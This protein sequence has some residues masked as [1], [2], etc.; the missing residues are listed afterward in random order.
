MPNVTHE[1]C[2]QQGELEIDGVSMHI[3][4]CW[5]CTNVEQLWIP[6]AVR[7]GENV[8]IPY[9]PGR[10]AVPWRRDQAVYDVEL[11]FAG[12]NDENGTDWPDYRQGLTEN[13][14][15]FQQLIVDSPAPVTT[16]PAQITLNTGT[17]IEAHVQPLVLDLAPEQTL[18]WK[19]VL[20]LV[21]PEG[22]FQVGGS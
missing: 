19:A 10:T 2:V 13:V 5:N 16:V 7:G 6:N 14:L 9:T 15:T 17:Q 3:P 20:T 12:L 21:V 22:V 4:G 18:I 8:V 1:A 11:V